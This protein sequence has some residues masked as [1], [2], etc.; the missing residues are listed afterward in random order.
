MELEAG[1]GGCFCGLRFRSPKSRN[2]TSVALVEETKKTITSPQVNERGETASLP[3]SQNPPPSYLHYINHWYGSPDITTTN[4]LWTPE[5]PPAYSEEEDIPPE[6]LATMEKH[7]KALSPQLRQLS[8]DIWGRYA[9]DRLTALMTSHGFDVTPHYLGLAT[10]FRAAYTHAPTSKSP[11]EKGAARSTRVI[12]VNAEMDA[13]PGI[14]HAC[15]HNLIAMAG[16][17]VALALKAALAA[18]GVPGTIVLLGTPAEEGGGGKIQLL[19]RGAY[20]EMDACVMCHPAAGPE[21]SA[22]MW[23][24]VAAQH[25]EIEF[26][27]HGAHAGAAPWEG[28]NALD[29]A[30]VAYSAISALR[31]QI[32]P[33]HRVHGVVSGRN[34]APNVIPD[35]ALLKYIVRAPTW[36]E[37]EVLRE[38]ILA[39]FQAAALATA[40]KVKISM[41][42]GYYE[43]RNNSVLGGVFSRVVGHQY[44]MGMS[45][46]EGINASTDFG[47]VTFELPAIH[48]AY[49]IRTEPNGAN[50]TPQFAQSA[51]SKQAH[52]QTLKVALGLAA[53]GFKVLDDAKFMAKAKEAF[54]AA[55]AAHEAT[56]SFASDVA[57]AHGE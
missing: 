16:V 53:V 3:E 51:R 19:E 7:L 23:K 18:H 6:V 38:R 41:D 50:H 54:E 44:G 25:M 20:R 9:H 56:T 5:K 29:A 21:N 34:W 32:K 47:N 31:Q 24:S 27:G 14:G 28:Q 11:N 43:L 30:F 33:D 48:P 36:A 10:A 2:K 35:Y 4:T 49:A 1:C 57:L 26:F 8:L 12:G 37:L 46:A 15:G 13:L 55:K 22:M 39:C 40:C 17:G 52:E 45:T 42:H